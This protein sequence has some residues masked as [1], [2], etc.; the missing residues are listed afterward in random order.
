MED[1]EILN[2][3]VFRVHVELDLGHGDVHVDAV[4]DLAQGGTEKAVLESIIL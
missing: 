2:V 1:L 4:K 3:Q